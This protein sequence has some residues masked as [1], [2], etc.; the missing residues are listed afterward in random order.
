MARVV[1]HIPEPLLK[2]LSQ[3]GYQPLKAEDQ[4]VFDPYY[5]AM[6]A[7][8]A[9]SVSFPCVLAWSDAIPSFY[10]PVGGKV[11]LCLQY[12]GT[13][14]EWNALPFIGRYSPESFGEAFRVLRGD[15]E[16]LR[17]PLLVMEA[18][19]WMLPFYESAGGVSW[20]ISRPREWADYIY[21]RTD[22][23][24]SLNSSDSRYRYRY[25]LRRFSPETFVLT[26][27][28]REECLECMRAVWCSVTECSECFACPLDAVGNVAGALD[29]LRADGLLVRVDG[30]PA[31]FCI[32]SCRNGFGVYHFKHADNRM[33]GINEYL[34]HECLTRF[35]SGAEEINFT[36][37]VGIESLRAYKCKLAPYTLA[38][39]IMLRK[40]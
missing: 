1:N 17:L 38:H 29:R 26:P 16:A 35:M 5:D 19:E 37:D 3:L 39:R 32:V 34:L 28:R 15:M 13:L 31:G 10:K 2:Q 24:T 25:F 22:F 11:L 18:S 36:N 6:N 9:S 27:E 30:K 7:P 8:W 14:K 20:E 40:R 4:R 12:D 33:K 21:R 23:E